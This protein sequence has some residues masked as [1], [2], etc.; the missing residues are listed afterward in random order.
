MIALIGADGKL[1]LVVVGDISEWND[2]STRERVM[3][4]VRRKAREIDAKLFLVVS[5]TW[6]RKLTDDILKK[7][8]MTMTS[9]QLLSDHDQSILIEKLRA[10]IEPQEGIMVMLESQE[11]TT[12]GVMLYH[13][14]DGKVVSFD[15]PLIDFAKT[16]GRMAN[17][18]TKIK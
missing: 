15:E 18:L 7:V 12:S 3:F 6:Q 11:T 9:F 16:G 10:Q 4:W 13:R 14:K 2:H 5:D 1:H 17:I 8:G